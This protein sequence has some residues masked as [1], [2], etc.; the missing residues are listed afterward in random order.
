VISGFVSGAHVLLVQWEAWVDAAVAGLLFPLALVILLSGLDDLALD[1]V[2]LYAWI[3]RRL[4]RPLAVEQAVEQKE[5]PRGEKGIAIFVP[6]WHEH[7]VIAGMVEHNASAI[8][9]SRYHFFIGAY[10]NDDPTLD[11]VRDLEVRFPHVHLAVCPHNGPTSKA[12]CLNWI[13]QRMLLY[14]E[15]YGVSFDVVI[16][17]DAED[18]IH[19]EAFSFVNA[20][21]GEFD[22]VQIPVL[23]LPTPLRDLVHGIYCDEFA[24]WQ[25]KDMPGRQIMGS[26][27]PS[28]GVGTGFT[29]CALEKLACAEHNLIFEPACLTEDYENG[30]RLH[31]FGCKQMFVPLTKCGESIVATREFFPRTVRTAIRQRSRW[32]LGIGLQ[33]WERHGWRGRPTEIYWFWRDR[34]GLFGNP[35]SLL[36]NIVFFYGALTWF[37]AYFSGAPWGIAKYALHPWLLAAT[38]GIQVVQTTVRM[39]CTARLYGPV[40]ALAVPLRSVCGN[41][42]NTIATWKAARQYLRARFRHEPL[43]WVKTEHA[44]PSRSALVEHKRKLGEILIGSAYLEGSEV[45]RALESQPRGV[46][47]GEHLVRLGKITEEELYEALSVQQSLPSGRLEPWVINTNIARALPRRVVHEWR[48]LPFRVASGN[49]FLASPEIPSDD[50]TRALRGFTRLSLRFHLVTPGNFQEL[51]ESLL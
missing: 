20:Y 16:T 7:A 38:L 19:P 26:F 3:T 23:P 27:V 14:E 31:K 4:S 1:G 32:I 24:E 22:M 8:N 5:S 50:L 12:D 34:K 11:A 46:R 35:I 40:F 49:L 25:I 2:C 45:A 6:L 18:L 15:R 47:I 48:V 41:W 33:S 29:R 13:Y 36:S 17:H 30:L 21:A 43:V 28:N 9:Y 51:T 44:Y 42:I 37:V 10:P 39:G